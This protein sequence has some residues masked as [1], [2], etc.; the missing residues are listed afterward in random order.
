MANAFATFISPF[1][2]LSKY[3]NA[4]RHKLEISHRGSGKVQEVIVLISWRWLRLSFRFS[5]ES[6]YGHCQFTNWNHFGF[7][8]I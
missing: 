1:R 4:I 5:A 6:P 8:Q 3:A 7:R 2:I